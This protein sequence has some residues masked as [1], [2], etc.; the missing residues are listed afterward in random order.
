MQCK[1]LFT[2]VALLS[3]AIVAAGCGAVAEPMPASSGQG[4][5]GGVGSGGS[6]SGGSSNASPSGTPTGMSGC[7]SPGDRGNAE[8]VGKYCSKGGNQCSGNGSATFCTADFVDGPSFCTKPCSTDA[9][10]GAGAACNHQSAGSGCVPAT[11]GAM[12]P[13]SSA[14]AGLAPATDGGAP[15][16]PPPPPPTGGCGQPG[17][18]GNSLGVGKYC[19]KGGNQCSGNGQATICTVDYSSGPGFC[20]KQCSVDA[21]CGANAHCVTESLGSGCEPNACSATAT[22]GGAP[23]AGDGGS[24]GGGS[25]NGGCALWDF[26]CW[27]S[28]LGL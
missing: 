27:L 1:T 9:D 6:G 15:P 11:C 14:D 26:G 5:G 3:N 23:P 17:D 16:P 22:D 12:G 10:C 7:G 20:T 19:S 2:V 21:D 28:M 4:S 8:G 24:G 25:G 13:G 18:V